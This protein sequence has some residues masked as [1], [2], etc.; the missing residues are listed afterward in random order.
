[1]CSMMKCSSLTRLSKI[2]TY[3]L[4]V[5]AVQ[6]SPCSS[7]RQC[8]GRNKVQWCLGEGVSHDK[9]KKSVSK[10]NKDA[11]MQITHLKTNSVLERWK[12]N[13]GK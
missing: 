6:T 1:M 3:R 9:V 5:G 2:S 4:T 7:G 11:A 12:Y 13:A 8:A 10:Q